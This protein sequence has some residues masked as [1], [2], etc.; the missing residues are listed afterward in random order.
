MKMTDKIT[1]QDALFWVRA[2][3]DQQELVTACYQSRSFFLL[4][5]GVGN[6]ASVSVWRVENAHIS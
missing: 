6:L 2:Q 1:W 3:P 5:P 4:K